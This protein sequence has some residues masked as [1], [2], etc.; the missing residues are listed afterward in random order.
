MLINEIDLSWKVVNSHLMKAKVP[1]F[2]IAV[3]HANM[4]T[5][6]AVS[7]SIAKPNVIVEVG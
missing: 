6:V 2:L 7:S 5:A 4:M 3:R 1:I